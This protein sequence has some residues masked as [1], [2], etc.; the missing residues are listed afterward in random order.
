M[1]SFTEVPAWTF[2]G[3]RPGKHTFFEAIALAGMEGKRIRL[4]ADTQR[5]LLGYA[6]FGRRQI[7]V[8]RD[9]TVEC[10]VSC[11][12]GLDFESAQWS[13]ATV[14]AAAQARK[15]LCPGMSGGRY[16]EGRCSE[17]S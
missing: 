17:E 4:S 10:T 9:G 6:V 14:S 3:Q 8:H 7:V 15:Q 5:A 11:C 1:P 2:E 13:A 12:F 16:F